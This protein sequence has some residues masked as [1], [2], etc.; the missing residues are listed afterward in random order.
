MKLTK[1]SPFSQLLAIR[2]L[3]ERNLVLAAQRHDELLVRFLLARLVEHAHVRLAAV[4]RLAGLA[5]AA[6]QSVVDQRNLQH[7]LE[8]VQDG[9]LAL[10]GGGIGADFDFVGG[11]DGGGW[12]FSVRLE[13]G[14]LVLGDG[15]EVERVSYHVCFF[16]VGFSSKSSGSFT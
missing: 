15:G 11:R 14:V 1:S 12:L 8:R 4:E 2:H 3:D 13:R 7:A 10:A 6:R 9:H 16:D 5:Q